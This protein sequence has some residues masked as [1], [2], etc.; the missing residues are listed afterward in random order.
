MR[1]NKE[2]GM[3]YDGEV[4]LDSLV[5]KGNLRRGHLS[6]DLNTEWHVTG[7]RVEGKGFRQRKEQVKRS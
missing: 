4:I 2:K 6:T 5:R 1:K 3:T 7:Y